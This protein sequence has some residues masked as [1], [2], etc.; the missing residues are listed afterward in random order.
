MQERHRNGRE[1][2]REGIGIEGVD[3]G[4]CEM[5]S[6]EGQTKSRKVKKAE[7]QQTKAK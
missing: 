2:L 1:I 6:Y 3:E 5:T 7:E 4:K